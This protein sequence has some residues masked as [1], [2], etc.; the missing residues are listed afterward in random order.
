MK[1][2]TLDQLDFT[3][4]LLADHLVEGRQPEAVEAY[5][6]VRRLI[7]EAIAER[8]AL[9]GMVPRADLLAELA[10]QYVAPGS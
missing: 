2:R 5:T 8:D 7:A 9:L 1:T 10:G 6:R 4:R 3:V